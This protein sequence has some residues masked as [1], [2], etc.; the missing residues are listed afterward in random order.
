MSANLSFTKAAELNTENTIPNRAG[1]WNINP[2]GICEKGGAEVF[3]YG[4][5]SQAA[6]AKCI[7]VVN[8]AE[9]KLNTT[10]GELF[11]GTKYQVKTE[12]QTR[13][14]QA[15]R[16][17]CTPKT[18]LSYLEE[19]GIDALIRLFDT[20]GIEAAKKSPT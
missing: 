10:I 12:A 17:A 1:S 2:C 20:V 5:F 14:R 18:M 8:K 16:L 13:A 3:W 7:K 15:V 11:I 9:E 6:H 19:N 4:S